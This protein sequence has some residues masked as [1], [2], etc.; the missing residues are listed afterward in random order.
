MIV[1]VIMCYMINIF[2]YFFWWIIIMMLGLVI[3]KVD[4]L[5]LKRRKGNFI[6]NNIKV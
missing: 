6:I 2:I 1:I 5:F 3:R 4:L